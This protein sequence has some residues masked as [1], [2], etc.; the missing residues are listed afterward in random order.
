VDATEARI[1][2]EQNNSQRIAW[3]FPQNVPQPLQLCFEIVGRCL[4]HFADN[5][6]L[7]KIDSQDTQFARL[8][9]NQD[10]WQ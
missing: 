10:D 5:Q 7:V 2:T 6:A 3:R 1:K 8:E 4:G 9:F